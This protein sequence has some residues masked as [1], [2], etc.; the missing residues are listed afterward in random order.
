MNRK[1]CRRLYDDDEKIKGA[2]TKKLK[3]NE[4]KQSLEKEHSVIKEFLNTFEE[5][6]FN[7]RVEELFLRSMLHRQAA[8]QGYE[9]LK[10]ENANNTAMTSEQGT[11]SNNF[12][13]VYSETDLE[14]LFLNLGS[15]IIT[16]ED[17]MYK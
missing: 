15:D 5:M 2:N 10:K 11:S 13:N 14:P 16:S 9:E 4:T 7:L 17:E 8:R 3:I 1:R 6:V 12:T